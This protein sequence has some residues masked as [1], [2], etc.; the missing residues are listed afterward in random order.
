METSLQL[1]WNSA[2]IECRVFAD[3]NLTC[4]AI[5][6]TTEEWEWRSALGV[7]GWLHRWEVDG[8]RT[9][10]GGRVRH[11]DI[12]K[13]ILGWV[14]LFESS[15]T[16]RMV[17]RHV[18]AHNGTH[19]NERADNLAKEGAELRFKLMELAAPH[20]WFRRSVERYWENRG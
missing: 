10:G 2:H 16:R 3:C 11:T 19:G 4:L 6:N 13:R 14:R 17:I 12:W 7:S 9:S 8:W 18:K 20:D 15:P 1:A 5:D